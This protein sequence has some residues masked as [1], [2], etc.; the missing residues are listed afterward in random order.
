MRV[1]AQPADGAANEELVRHI[2]TRLQVP[3]QAVT[4]AHGLSSR[5]KTIRV[6]GL[7]KDAVVKRLMAEN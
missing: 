2:A 5:R 7:T 1:A 4:I 3:R 6:L